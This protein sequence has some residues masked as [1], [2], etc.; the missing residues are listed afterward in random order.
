MPPTLS[1]G[2]V[3]RVAALTVLVHAGIA[4]YAWFFR[5][6]HGGDFLRY[7]TVATSLGRPYVDFQVEYPPGAFAVLKLLSFSCQSLTQY[8]SRLLALNMVADGV[9]FGSL[10]R[11]WGLEAAAVYG[12]AATPILR[13]LYFR[14]D[15]W[16][17]AI[18]TLAAW[19][20][21]RKQTGA[22]AIAVCAGASLK[23]WPVFFGAWLL[24]K[25]KARALAVGTGVAGCL[26]AGLWVAW[27]GWGGIAQVL[28]FRGASGWQF[29]SVIGSVVRALDPA[30]VRVESGADRVG[31]A[32]PWMFVALFLIAVP[33][34]V[35]ASW[36]GAATGRLGVAWLAAIAT[37]LL[38]SALF[39]T[40]Y[41]G[42]LLP[43][44]GIAWAGGQR[45]TVALT[46]LVVMVTA[47][48][49]AVPSLGHPVFG[50]AVPLVILRNLVLMAMAVE[51]Y[52]ELLRA[53]TTAP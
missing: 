20:W 44:M 38:C 37:L 26:A 8:E 34:A 10:A 30:S 42:W 1:A 3:R 4:L 48:Y 2:F 47:A 15:L 5:A 18:A 23:L 22:S 39:S 29:E 33:P 24:T 27:A 17:M 49:R 19:A 11:G 52:R 46:G 36:R 12:V 13:L 45:R 25:P 31:S 40:Q 6:H 14:M 53:P 7:W 28:T 35:W 9:I 50:P 21:K 32:Q 16:S 51:A 41:V 43:A